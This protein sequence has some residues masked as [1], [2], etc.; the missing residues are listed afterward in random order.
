MAE[1][2]GSCAKEIS[3]SNTHRL[4]CNPYTL[5]YC[6]WSDGEYMSCIYKYNQ[7]CLFPAH[8]V[9]CDKMHKLQHHPVTTD[10]HKLL[11]HTCS[12]YQWVNNNFH[13]KF[14]RQSV[15]LFTQWEMQ[16]EASLVA[17]DPNT[18]TTLIRRMCYSAGGDYQSHNN[19]AINWIGH[20]F[21]N[22]LFVSR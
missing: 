11:L 15:N 19:H 21:I 4:I 22:A 5:H 18:I 10:R 17:R 12:H 13:V 6:S 14:N 1:G 3:H 9:K 20:N 7:Q 8:I 16:I 2:S